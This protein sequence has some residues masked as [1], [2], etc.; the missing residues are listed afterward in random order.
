[1]V[2]Q[3]IKKGAG[4]KRSSFAEW[5]SSNG[6]NDTKE[7]NHCNAEKKQDWYLLGSA[8]QQATKL[9]GIPKGRCISILGHSNTGKSTLINHAIVAAQKQGDIPVIIDTENNFSFHYAI[10]MGMDATPVY[11]D[12]ER[13]KYDEETGEYI[14]E[15]S[16]EI[17]HYDG[18]FMY[19]NSSLL[20]DRYGDFDYSTN[21]KTNKKRR[22]V[23]IE[24]VA[25]FINEIINAQ[26]EGQITE[27]ILFIWD[28]VGSVSSWKAY[29]SANNNAMWDAAAIS[30]SFS[31]IV[32][33]RIASTRN[34]SCP[35][36]DTFL[37]V[38]KVWMDATTNPVGPP[39]MRT[40]G[41]ASLHYATRLQI[42]LGGKLTA[43]VKYL[44]ATSK[45][46]NYCY[47]TQ[48]KIKIEKNQLDSPYNI[49]YSGPIIIGENGFM[50]P[51]DL[52]SYR[53]THVASILKELNSRM[54]EGS[55]NTEDEI[56][57]KDIQ[58]VEEDSTD[59]AN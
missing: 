19:M 13:E 52:D 10:Q 53:K 26:E 31:N 38:N 50:R 1:M 7:I 42:I 40:K 46:Q 56:T 8:Y 33:N 57:E 35:Y 32:N 27:S 4:I 24:D 25:R 2:K 37:Y 20:C 41:G 48:S 58:Y 12:V 30:T 44:I 17:V 51:E 18:P 16:N 55:S 14:T 21:K 47:A 59:E 23:V 29:N 45:G 49:E 6:F 36:T 39:I 5:K 9:P 54:N 43:G 28:S 11:G 3:A 15:T 22:T 34:V